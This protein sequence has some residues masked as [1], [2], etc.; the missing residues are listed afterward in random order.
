[1]TRRLFDV[2]LCIWYGNMLCSLTPQ[3]PGAKGE[4]N[5]LTLICPY[6]PPL[7]PFKGPHPLR[8]QGKTVPWP[9]L[10]STAAT[11]TV[12]LPY[13]DTGVGAATWS[14][15]SPQQRKSHH[16]TL[17]DSTKRQ[18]APNTLQCF[19][20]KSL[21]KHRGVIWITMHDIVDHGRHRGIYHQRA[22]DLTLELSV[23]M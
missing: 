5:A 18:A 4:R 6:I 15:S 14:T 1:M 3:H 9:G 13:I 22:S 10:H 23:P 2:S 8:L 16:Y 19:L 7:L 11:N 20:A 21:Y 12:I 17:N